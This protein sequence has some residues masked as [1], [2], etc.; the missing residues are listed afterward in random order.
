ME[1]CHDSATLEASLSF[2][3]C[4]CSASVVKET[5]ISCYTIY[6][7]LGIQVGDLFEYIENKES[8]EKQSALKG[9]VRSK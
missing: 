4:L 2:S 9:K 6:A 8:T 5:S 1:R 3:P 7:A